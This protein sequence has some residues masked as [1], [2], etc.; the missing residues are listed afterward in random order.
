MNQKE[1]EENNNLQT[2][3]KEFFLL[4]LVIVLVYCLYI[5]IYTNYDWINNPLVLF[6]AFFAI[7]GI[8][9]T[10]L[11]LLVTF[12]SKKFNSRFNSNK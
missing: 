2:I 8:I 3:L 10:V 11:D 5:I 6:V 7:V 4:I 1:K 12:G 9:F